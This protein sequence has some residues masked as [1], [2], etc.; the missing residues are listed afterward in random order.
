MRTLDLK[1]LRELRRHWVQVTSIALVM[2]CGTMTIMGLRS[3]LTSIRAARD[4]YFDQYRFADVFVRLQRT[5][6][7]VAARIAEID[8]VAS[9]ES[10]IVEDVKLDVPRLPEP[11]IGHVVS[12]PDVP[13][14]MLNDLEI[15]RGRWLTP[16]RDDEVLVS[17]RFAELNHLAPG[18][19]V[20][21]VING[22]WQRLRIVG[23]A[24]S[25][26]FVVEFAGGGFFVDN[27]RYGV[28]WASAR[29]LENA[30][31]MEGAFNDVA[32][33]LAPG[34]NELAVI[35]DLDRLLQPWGSAGAH[36]RRDQPAARALDDEFTQLRTNATVFPLFFLIVA[37]YLLNVVLSRLV[38][39]QRDEIAALKAFGYTDWE[40]GLHYLGFGVAAV[41][42]GAA[43]GIPL[44]IWMGASFTA[45]YQDY[46]RFPSLPTVTDWTAAL[47][48]VGVSG[49]FALLGALSG[50]RRVMKLAPAEALRPD[51]PAKFRPLLIEYLGLGRF[52]GSALRMVLRNL[53]RRPI[54]T[55]ATVIGVALAV[56]L[57]ASGRFPYDAFDRLLEVEFHLAQRY[58]AVATFTDARPVSA[59]R[60]L[61]HVDGV[62]SAIP[63]RTAAVRITRGAVSRTTSITGLEPDDDLYHLVDYEGHE[64]HAPERGCVM[65]LGLARTLGVTVGDTIRAELIEHGVTRRVVVTGLFDPMLGEGIYLS[66]RGMN[67]LLREQDA[68]NGA[69]LAIAPGREADVFAALKDFPGVAGAVSRAATIA[70]IDEQMRQSMTFVLTLIITS[71]SVIAMGVVYN[72][73]RIALSERGREL[74]SLRVLGFTSNEV[75]GMLLG[76]QAAIMLLA[77]PAGVGIGALFSFVLARGFKTER[78]HFPYVLAFDS[79]LLAIGVV[80]VAA[81]VASLVVRR[82]IGRLDMVAALRSRE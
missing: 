52:V 57:L 7:A 40:I 78:F 54:R 45:L 28:L 65:A 6:A 11:A 58:D 76:E 48:A 14:P 64:Y 12:V 47:I 20:A 80:L 3:T 73:A 30:F 9:V 19:S 1:L 44:G 50:V 33:R 36:G 67:A 60:E 10:R 42:L 68:A 71:G 55:T 25:P 38:A 4:S 35:A 31:D 27:R 24:I 46:F 41:A 79:Q 69:H 37:A 81:A 17:E 82:R 23:I 39:S 34:A 21:A 32:V 29:T 63:F 53:E 74:A 13:R 66:R 26:E 51:S 16:G 61:R 70:N 15:R 18:D 8:G 43:V 72:S 75:A 59:A 5:P 56:A 22:R 49:G 62:L 77:L 2:G